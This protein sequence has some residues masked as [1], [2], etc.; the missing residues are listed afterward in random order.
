MAGHVKHAAVAALCLSS[1]MGAVAW[2]MG[3]SDPFVAPRVDGVLTPAGQAS[4]AAGAETGDAP[5]AAGLS[6]VRLGRYAGAVID[7]QWIR[8]GHTVRGAR[9][10]QIQR[11]RVTLQHPDGHQEIIE[12]FP[13]AGGQAGAVAAASTEAVKP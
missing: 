13:P 1:L 9:L 8:K 10:V 6:G 12:M 2:A 3:P 7:G 5:A 11:T 4:V